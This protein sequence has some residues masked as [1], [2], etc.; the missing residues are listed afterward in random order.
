MRGQDPPGYVSKGESKM[1]LRELRKLGAGFTV[2]FLSAFFS[3]GIFFFT[4]PSQG[5]G[6]SRAIATVDGKAITEEELLE[7]VGGEL[8]RLEAKTYQARREALESL[9]FRLLLKEEAG[10]RGISPEELFSE[11]VDSK[12]SEPTE[13]EMKSLYQKNR[14][15]IRLPFEK[16][17]EDLKRYL[18]QRKKAQLKEGLFARLRKGRDIRILLEPPRVE[19]SPDDDPTLG[20]PE[21]PVTIIEFSDFQC[22]YCARIQ[23]ALKEL[24]RRYPK[25]VRLVFRDFPIEEIHPQ[26]L[27][28]AEAAQCAGDQGKFWP[29][30]D[31][32]FSNRHKLSIEALKGYARK[33]DLELTQFDQCLSQDKYQEEVRRDMR[34]GLKSGV[35]STP[36]F[37]INGRLISGAVPLEELEAV[38]AEE[39]RLKAGE[40]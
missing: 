11:E 4:P 36:T 29:Y 14:A 33:L 15:R 25:E 16:I 19:V 2:C 10:R 20:P 23:S 13:E 32:L 5:A 9:I 6:A 24:L 31:L 38:I 35:N 28:A 21:A 37:F 27:K 18:F 3:A 30:H 39:L 1:K 12:V 26:A 17:K 40:K 7:A 8:I 34:D 22:P